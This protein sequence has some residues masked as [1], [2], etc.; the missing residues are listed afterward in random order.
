M[1]FRKAKC[2][3]VSTGRGLE[4]DVPWREGGV[5]SVE[6]ASVIKN[7]SS[8]SGSHGLHTVVHEQVELLTLAKLNSQ[9]F[10]RISRG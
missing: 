4:S 3:G 5:V 6:R 2:P 10:A 1:T 9:P 7:K 8:A